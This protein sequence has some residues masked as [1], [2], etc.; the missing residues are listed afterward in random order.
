LE[1]KGDQ[2]PQLA[3]SPDVHSGHSSIGMQATSEMTPKAV[4]G[5]SIGCRFFESAAGIEAPIAMEAPAILRD[6]FVLR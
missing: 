2:N 3:S 1:E 4:I 6:R 5:F